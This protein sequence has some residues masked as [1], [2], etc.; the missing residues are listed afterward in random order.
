MHG[1]RQ[2][3]TLFQIVLPAEEI[4]TNYSTYLIVMHTG[5][6][7]IIWS[8]AK[9]TYYYY[10]STKYLIMVNLLRK[11]IN[12]KT[13]T[14]RVAQLLPL[15]SMFQQKYYACVKLLEEKNIPQI[16]YLKCANI[17]SLFFFKNIDIFF[18]LSISLFLFIFD[19]CE[20]RTAYT[21]WWTRVQIIC[22]HNFIIV[23]SVKDRCLKY[24]SSL[25][26]FWIW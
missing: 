9:N 26:I 18:S 12:S 19:A 15:T 2:G 23:L 22:E 8:D 25:Y 13:C 21:I 16:I 3:F 11:L 24:F 5:S 6:K 4:W 1:G 17:F 14:C 7:T 10:G 20:E